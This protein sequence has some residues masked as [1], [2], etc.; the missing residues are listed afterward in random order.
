ML[1]GT[2]NV[3]DS[4]S[5]TPR[6][7]HGSETQKT[8]DELQSYYSQFDTFGKAPNFASDAIG[9]KNGQST[10]LR[11]NVAAGEKHGPQS[12][13]KLPASSFDELGSAWPDD[14][15]LPDS[16][17]DT[18]TTKSVHDGAQRLTSEIDITEKVIEATRF[19]R[20][21]QGMPLALRMR[22]GKTFLSLAERVEGCST[23]LRFREYLEGGIFLKSANFCQRH[24]LCPWCARRRALKLLRQHM[25][26]LV[27]LLDRGGVIPCLMTLTVK[28]GPDLRERIN[29]LSASLLKASFRRRNCLDGKRGK[30][31]EFSRIDGAVWHFEVSRNHETKEWHPH[32]H[33]LVLR[34]DSTPFNAQNLRAEWHDITKDSNIVDIK[35]LHSVKKMWADGLSIADGMKHPSCRQQLVGDLCEVFKYPLKFQGL[36]SDECIDVYEQTKGIRWLREWGTLFRTVEPVDLADDVQRIGDLF[37]DHVYQ[38]IV[39]SSSYSSQ[40]V[41]DWETEDGGY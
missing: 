3:G 10:G 24:R 31:S 17:L 21:S 12:G 41:S 37:R 19:K 32:V 5:E 20:F 33:G 34:H 23:Y 29:H 8:G 1:Q 22:G 25:E 13:V 40:S 26:K 27:P 6:K 4:Q 39:E 36:S 35:L 15:V 11:Q 2:S 28:N 14:V 7:I 18:N 38:W 30:F 16:L 9:Q